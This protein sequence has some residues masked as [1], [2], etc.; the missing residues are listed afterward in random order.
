M[1]YLLLGNSSRSL[2]NR[3]EQ[4]YEIDERV[5]KQREVARYDVKSENAMCLMRNVENCVKFSTKKSIVSQR[6]GV[7]LDTLYVRQIHRNAKFTVSI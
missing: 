2:L 7:L 4:R 6:N 5:K 1:F 3:R